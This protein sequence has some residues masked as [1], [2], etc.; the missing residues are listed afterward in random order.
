VN[1]H[2]FSKN[3]KLDDVKKAVKLRTAFGWKGY[4]H[5]IWSNRTGLFS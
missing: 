2:N 4:P 5:T 1:E 3:T